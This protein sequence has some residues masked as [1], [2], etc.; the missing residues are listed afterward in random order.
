MI[1]RT[2]K[3]LHVID[4]IKDESNHSILESVK[5]IFI[6]NPDKFKE[7]MSHHIKRLQLENS[8]LALKNSDPA[9]FESVM[10]AVNLLDIDMLDQK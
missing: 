7:N 10:D 3:F 5:K 8:I 6:E 9:L 1:D 4:A 2:K